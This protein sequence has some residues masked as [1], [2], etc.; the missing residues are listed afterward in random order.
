MIPIVIYDPVK[1]LNKIEKEL[2]QLEELITDAKDMTAVMKN[3]FSIIYKKIQ[4][5]KH[6]L[7]A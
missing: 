3:N 2:V 4:M 5:I 6:E 1:N 7:P